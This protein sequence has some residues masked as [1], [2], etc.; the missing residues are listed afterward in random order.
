[1]GRT[2]CAP[3]FRFNPS[4]DEFAQ[5]RWYNITKENSPAGSLLAAF[6]VLLVTAQLYIFF[7]IWPK[8]L[9]SLIIQKISNEIY[10][11]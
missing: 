9:E 8:I 2:T 7:V 1:M 3:V 11:F 4:E 5:L 6:E 10:R